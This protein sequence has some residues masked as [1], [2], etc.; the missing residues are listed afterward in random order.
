MTTLN[1]P[2][3]PVGQEQWDKFV[4]QVQST[5]GTTTPIGGCPSPTGGPAGYPKHRD[6]LQFVPQVHRSI[7]AQV[8]LEAITSPT[9]DDIP[10]VL[11]T[12]EAQLRE[13]AGKLKPLIAAKAKAN[14]VA[15]GGAVPQ[16][17][18]EPIETR[19]EVAKLA[20]VSH[21]TIA[22]VET[23]TTMSTSTTSSPVRPPVR[24]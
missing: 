1:R 19:Q 14:Q 20:G 6:R 9:G 3:G 13:L 11:P 17:S 21:D 15:S 4:P 8:T 22:K 5:S 23:I 24:R 7:N 10:A 18:A 16:K 2:V 12:N